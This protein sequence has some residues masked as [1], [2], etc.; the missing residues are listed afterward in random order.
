LAKTYD[1]IEAEATK[2]PGPLAENIRSLAM[3]QGE[4]LFQTYEKLYP[5]L[6]SDI[7]ARVIF[8]LT[9]LE[10]MALSKKPWA[11]FRKFT[12]L[13]HMSIAFLS[14]RPDF[15]P[16]LRQVLL[17]RFLRPGQEAPL[18]YGPDRIL[19]LV[20][21]GKFQE[22]ARIR[23]GTQILS[24]VESLRM[25]EVLRSWRAFGS[26]LP[27]DL[28]QRLPKA[29]ERQGLEVLERSAE[30]L[31]DIAEETSVILGSYPDPDLVETVLK[32][33]DEDVEETLDLARG[34]RN[35]AKALRR[36][37]T[38]VEWFGEFVQDKARDYPELGEI[39]QRLERGKAFLDE[40][41]YG[42]ENAQ[43]A[44]AVLGKLDDLVRK[45]FSQ[46]RSWAEIRAEIRERSFPQILRYENRFFDWLRNLRQRGG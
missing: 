28:L 7:E 44:Y 27:P 22:L 18:A 24:W 31:R 3:E 12:Y 42:L 21:A 6:P 29:I 39:A 23:P 35:P 37:S 40:T 16:Q 25:D 17:P 13:P 41:A 34:T 15:G 1:E 43:D 46:G 8:L 20:G 10:S 11:W 14:D 30:A 26:V 38:I 45:R 19:E 4:R 9:G 5:V 2:L 36:L 33:L 32:Y